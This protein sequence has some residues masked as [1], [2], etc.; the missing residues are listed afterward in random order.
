[1]SAVSRARLTRRV[2][3]QLETLYSPDRQELAPTLALH[4]EHGREYGRAI[5]YLLLTAEIAA[6]RFA[7]RESIQ[8]LTPALHTVPSVAAADRTPLVLP[9]IERPED[10]HYAL[11]AMS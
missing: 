1:M 7:P 4:F 6:R 5:H 9:A 10:A 3:Q 2:A 11:A 8:L